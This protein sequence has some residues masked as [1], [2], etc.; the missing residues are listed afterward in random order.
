MSSRFF[1]MTDKMRM[2]F[3]DVVGALGQL[4]EEQRGYIFGF[5]GEEDME[6]VWGVACYI[7]LEF[8]KYSYDHN[9]HT[10]SIRHFLD[11]VEDDS[12]RMAHSRVMGY[13][14]RHKKWESEIMGFDYPPDYKYSN[15]DM[16]D[17][18]NRI[19]GHHITEMNFFEHQNIRNLD[20]IKAIVER[21]IVSSKKVSN[22]RFQEMFEQYDSF[23]E[24]LIERSKKSDA[25]MV[26]ASLALFTFEWHYPVETFYLLSCL[27]EEEKTETVNPYDLAL[28]CTYM[29]IESR[30]IGTV[31][32]E[33]RM[34]KERMLVLPY[35]FG[36]KVDEFNRRTMVELVEEIL[37]LVV[38]F[39]ELMFDE[40]DIPYKEWFRRESSM[41]DWASF[42][43]YYDIFLIWQKK[44]WTRTRIQN[45]RYLFDLIL[46]PK[47]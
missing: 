45:M 34:A 28:L 40:N 7:V 36:K 43:R 35:I 47:M 22:E 27:M 29:P 26:F 23:V 17:I 20:L 12:E 39:K 41:V 4:P 21:R 37:A 6:W 33:S 42:F 25:D 9:D 38:Q 1:D 3:K 10:Y 14:I 18:S 24:A 11:N 30:F 46:A 16:S 2:L 15:L 32:S 44:E 31:F 13:V 19:S 8:I 5:D